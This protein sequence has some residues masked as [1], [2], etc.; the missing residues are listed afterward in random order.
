LAAWLLLFAFFPGAT[1]AM[2][3]FVI[4]ISGLGTAVPSAPGQ[5]GVMEAVVVAALS[6]FGLDRS[7]ALPYAI[8]FHI[9]NF[10]LTS[11]LGVIA[12]GR[13]GETISHLAQSAQSLL[14][15]EDRPTVPG[16][17]IPN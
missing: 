3:F 17:G 8:V 13:E 1:V 10:S 4:V 14:S 11:L 9:V 7:V 5:M 2:G 15:R 6:V 12:L 16:E